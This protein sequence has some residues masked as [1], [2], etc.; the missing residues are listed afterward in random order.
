MNDATE[1]N[2]A[3]APDPAP[4]ADVQPPA[5][6]AKRAKQAAARE[7]RKLLKAIDGAKDTEEMW[8]RAAAY[9]EKNGKALA[10]PAA[11]APG[12]SAPALPASLSPAQIAKWTPA[13]TQLWQAVQ[14]GL[15]AVGAGSPVVAEF[16]KA[17]AVKTTARLDAQGAPQEVQIDPVAILAEPTAEC[18]ALWLPDE[19]LHPAAKLGGALALVF[20]PPLVGLVLEM[21]NRKKPDEEQAEEPKAKKAA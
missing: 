12:A 8:A 20:G 3:P 18:A 9:A 6:P 11:A 7:K 2:E 5:D 17:M 21:A 10:K 19:T 15:G 14:L 16:A 1:Q 4:A 13:A